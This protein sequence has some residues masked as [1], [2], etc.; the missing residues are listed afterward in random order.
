MGVIIASLF[1]NPAPAGF[2]SVARCLTGG[3]P[4]R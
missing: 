3:L 1:L 2:F 4:E